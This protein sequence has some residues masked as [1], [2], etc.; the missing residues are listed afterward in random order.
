M[1]DYCTFVLR[2]SQIDQLP[3]CSISE[4]IPSHFFREKQVGCFWMTFPLGGECLN[5]VIFFTFSFQIL[6]ITVSG[7]KTELSEKHNE[8]TILPKEIAL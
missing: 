4:I 1:T 7:K 6:L 2:I 3:L 5:S 8:S